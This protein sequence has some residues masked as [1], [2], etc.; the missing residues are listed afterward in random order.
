[1]QINSSDIKNSKEAQTSKCYPLDTLETTEQQYLPKYAETIAKRTIKK[2]STQKNTYALIDLDSPLQ[3]VYWDTWHCCPIYLQE[4]RKMHTTLCRRKWCM[5]C[6]NIRTSELINGYKHLLL[7]FKEPC[8]VTVG[9]KN[10]KGRELKAEYAKMLQASRWVRRT[11]QRQLGIKLNGIRCWECTYNEKDDEYNPHFH[12]IIDGYENAQAFVNHWVSFWTKK[13]GKNYISTEAQHIAR[14]ETSKELLEAFKYSTKM[15]ADNPS[16]AKAQDWIYQCTKGKR[17]AQPFGSL[18]RVQISHDKQI[19]EA[20][21]DIE[22]RNEIWDWE[23]TEQA[24]ISAQGEYLVTDKQIE[25]YIANQ[26]AKK[27]NRQPSNGSDTSQNNK[28]NQA[29][30]GK[31][32]REERQNHVGRNTGTCCSGHDKQPN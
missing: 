28:G 22:E 19:T 11:I 24:Y 6:A 29:K 17:L 15:D 7:D 18:K 9:Q 16:K 31:A 13:R 21:Q 1:M 8:I 5:V 25:T 27:K 26:D 23:L 3:K 4:G 14:I 30:V 32:F 20:Y 12:I 10:C 2:R